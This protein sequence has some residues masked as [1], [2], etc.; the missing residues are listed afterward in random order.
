[1]IYF[2]TIKMDALSWWGLKSQVIILQIAQSWANTGVLDQRLLV[3]LLKNT[4]KVG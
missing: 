4:G 1:M 3:S 2:T